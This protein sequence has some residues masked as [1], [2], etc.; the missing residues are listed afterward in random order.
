MTTSAKSVIDLKPMGDRVVV[1]PSEQEGMTKGGI[2]LPDTAQERPQKG[3]VVATG[4]GRVLDNGKL[5][6]M[7]VKAGDTVIYSKYAGTEIEVQD[8]ELLVLGA[9]DILAVF[10]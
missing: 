10:T 9:N 2:F 8:Q 7:E 3:E 1:R 5:V 6:E 4:P